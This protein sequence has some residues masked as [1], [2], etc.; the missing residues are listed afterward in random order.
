MFP[1]GTSDH[2]V[3]SIDIQIVKAFEDGVAN[4]FS[5]YWMRSNV[6]D[7]CL[8]H[9]PG[10]PFY[11]DEFA[12]VWFLLAGVIGV[13]IGFWIFAKYRKWRKAKLTTSGIQET[14]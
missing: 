11:V 4:S 10:D 1:Q 7:G 14:E 6:D 2:T 12:G 3:N 5:N 9:N 13:A 8:A